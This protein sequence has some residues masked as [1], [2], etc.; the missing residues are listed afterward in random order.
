VGRHYA[1]IDRAMRPGIVGPTD[2]VAMAGTRISGFELE[3][4]V[5]A[6]DDL[7]LSGE[8]DFLSIYL[9]DNPDEE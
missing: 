2:L 4:A 3:T 9:L 7:L 5:D 6:L 1:A 8:L